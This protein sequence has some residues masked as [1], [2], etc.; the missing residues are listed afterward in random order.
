MK[1]ETLKKQFRRDRPMTTMTLSLPEDV[2]EDLDRI[3]PRRGLSNAKS[4]A[5]TYIGQGLREDLERFESDTVTALIASLER[6]GISDDLIEAALAE[7][8]Q[9]E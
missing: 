6:R 2:I 8:T 5:R 3:A 7:V 4:L 9:G 1:L